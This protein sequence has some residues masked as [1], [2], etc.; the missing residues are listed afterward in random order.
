MV[1]EDARARPSPTPELAR[2]HDEQ[3]KELSMTLLEV[4]ALQLSSSPALS[5]QQAEGDVR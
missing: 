4:P 2:V 3:N 5:K 1:T